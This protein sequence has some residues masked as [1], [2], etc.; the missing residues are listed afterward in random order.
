MKWIKKDIRLREILPIIK[1]TIIFCI[2]IDFDS[3]TNS[4]II[5]IYNYFMIYVG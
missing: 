4:K 1:Y 2:L 5:K 3:L